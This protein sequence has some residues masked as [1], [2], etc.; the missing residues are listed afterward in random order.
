MSAVYVSNHASLTLAWGFTGMM[1]P[2]RG[3]GHYALRLAHANLWVVSWLPKRVLT[4]D[5]ASIAMA[6]AR[7]AAEEKPHRKH[8]L[9]SLVK[10][11]AA[12][13]GMAPEEA[14]ARAGEPMGPVPWW[15]PWY[16]EYGGYQRLPRWHVGHDQRSQ[17]RWYLRVWRPRER[18]GRA[19]WSRCA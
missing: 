8:P 5:K 17:E 7:I 9:W 1:E 13:L 3:T 18:T 12:E 11:Y 6:L 16:R 2:A 14:L 10:R 4:F 15:S 19:D